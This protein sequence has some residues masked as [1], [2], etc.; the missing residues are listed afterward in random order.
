MRANLDEIEAIMAR[1]G[2]DGM[3][4]SSQYLANLVSAGKVNPEEALA[5][6]LRPGELAQTL[7]GR[8]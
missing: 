2:F 6:S 8:T 1:S 4:T 7:R 5:A 3:I